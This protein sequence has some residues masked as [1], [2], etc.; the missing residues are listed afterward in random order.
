MFGK[1]TDEHREKTRQDLEEVHHL[2][3][4]SVLEH[5]P[6]LDLDKV[7]TGEYWHGSRALELGLIDVLG[8]SDDYLIDAAQNASVYAVTYKGHEGLIHKMQS[9]LS[10][11][12][13]SVGLGSPL[14]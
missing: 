9:A 3:K 4:S 7:A 14:P 2:F 8:T 1:N 12:A 10:A 6:E 13:A 5:R 11:A